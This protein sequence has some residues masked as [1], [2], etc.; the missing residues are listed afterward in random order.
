MNLK[1]HE[2]V[3][4]HFLLYLYPTAERSAPDEELLQKI[5]EHQLEL[6]FRVHSGCLAQPIVAH[7]RLDDL[8]EEELVCLIEVGAKTLV[9]MSM[10]CEKGTDSLCPVP[11][12]A[13]SLSLRL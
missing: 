11:S 5:P 12:V 9:T 13:F 10:S 1:T 8:I 3:N 2:A 4:Y 7:R 6:A